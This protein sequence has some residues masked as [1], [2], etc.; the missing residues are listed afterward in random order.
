MRILKP[1]FTIA[2]FATTALAP[3]TSGTIAVSSVASI[4]LYSVAKN[5][6]DA[7]IDIYQDLIENAD[8]EDGFLGNITAAGL[9]SPFDEKFYQGI[10]E[11]TKD[12]R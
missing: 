12:E 10:S 11:L 3:I 7:A 5:D 9:S 6:Y 8:L 4:D 1:A 2:A